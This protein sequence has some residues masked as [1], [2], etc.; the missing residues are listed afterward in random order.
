MW[1]KNTLILLFFLVSII[2][3]SASEED[4]KIVYPARMI[5]SN[6]FTLLPINQVNFWSLAY[7][8]KIDTISAFSIELRYPAVSSVSGFGVGGEYRWHPFSKSPYRFYLAGRL[9]YT[10]IKDSESEAQVFSLGPILGWQFLLGKNVTVGLGFGIDYNTGPQLQE[11][12]IAEKNSN[13]LP[14]F[15]FD[16]G[17]SW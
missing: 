14:N 12:D 17:W 16:L 11:Q 3:L 5:T 2:K 13:V 1:I 15:R 8:Q 10:N 4:N 6:P 7:T 9:F